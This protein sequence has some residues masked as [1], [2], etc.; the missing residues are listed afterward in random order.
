M[1]NESATSSR[2]LKREGLSM[3]MGPISLARQVRLSIIND[4][5]IVNITSPASMSFLAATPRT[6]SC[7]RPGHEKH[8]H[9][10][11]HVSA[12][13]AASHCRNISQLASLSST[14]AS[15]EGSDIASHRCAARGAHKWAP[16]PQARPAA[17]GGRTPHFQ[18]NLCCEFCSIRPVVAAP[19]VKARL[20]CAIV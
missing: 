15:L 19:A 20:K 18:P 8:G 7:A 13:L 16:Q 12:P 4:P 11:R 1:N 5:G 10:R 3:K 6:P 2:L 9:C 14:A 17:R